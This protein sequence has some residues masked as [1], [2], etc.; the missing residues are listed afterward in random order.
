MGLVPFSALSYFVRLY[1]ILMLTRQVQSFMVATDHKGET[2]MTTSTNMHY[3]TRAVAH[4]C[5]QPA[6]STVTV[7]DASGSSFTL[8][9]EPGKAQAVADAINVARGFEVTA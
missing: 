4:E 2:E 1:R 9:L 5:D 7:H 8:M 6:F 3:A